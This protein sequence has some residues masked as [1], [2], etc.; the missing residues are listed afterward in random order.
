MTLGVILYGPPAAGK[1]TVTQELVKLANEYAPF[2]RI[3]VGRGR[4]DGYRMATAA[5]VERLRANGDL[6]WENER[7]G[8]TYIVD[9]AAL[10]NDLSRSIPVLHLGQPGGID[11]VLGAFP[12]GSWIVVY[13]WSS[14]S[15]A[16]ERIEARQTGDTAERLAAWDATPPV[17]ADIEINTDR[18]SAE[19]AARRIDAAVRLRGAL[20]PVSPGNG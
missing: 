17:D 14:R 3:K 16:A 13:V 6:L 9:Y 4:T 10:A 20:P 18:L 2:R 15:I 11:A 5:D 8:S 19:Q 12:S 1:D 7:Y